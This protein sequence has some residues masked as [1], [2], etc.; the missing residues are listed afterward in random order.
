MIGKRRA[1]RLQSDGLPPRL[2]V[3]DHCDWNASSYNGASFIWSEPLPLETGPTIEIIVARQGYDRSL[4]IFR[5]LHAVVDGSGALLLLRELFRAL[6]GE[7]LE[8]SNITFSDIDLQRSLGSQK[9]MQKHFKTMWLTGDHQEGDMGDELRRIS[10][11]ASKSNL[12]GHVAAAFAGFAHRYSDKPALMAIPVDLRRHLP[13]LRSSMHFANMLLVRMEKGDGPEIFRR[14]LQ[15]MLAQNV[16]IACAPGI[17]LIKTIPLP[18][19]D[20]LVSRNRWNYRWRSA[21]ETAV[22]TNVG[23]NDPSNFSAPGFEAEDMMVMALPG[24]A[25]ATICTLGDRAEMMINLP[26]VLASG[27]R[28]DALQEHL[29]RELNAH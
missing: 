6:R 4:I 21:M 9:V 27:G 28:F 3:L 13:G 25:F 20:L 23:R 19:F 12:L 16:D 22:I 26:K 24:S 18:L 14:R 11:P 29:L 8:G 2:R 5:G 1:A 10:L 15:E 17:D 7:A